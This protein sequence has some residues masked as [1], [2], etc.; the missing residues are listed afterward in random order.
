MTFQPRERQNIPESPQP[1]EGDERKKWYSGVR[2]FFRPPLS[3]KHF[4][5]GGI[6]LF[7]IV[8]GAIALVYLYAQSSFDRTWVA[9]NISGP[10]GVTSGEEVIYRVDCKNST[11]VN[12]NDAQLVFNWPAD[13]IP[14]SGQLIEQISI[15]TL[16]AGQE[17]VIEFKG[18]IIGLKNSQKQLSAK[19]SY[20]P[21]KTNARFEN[22]ST[23]A[24]RIISI[25]LVLTFDM[26]QRVANGQQITVSLKYLNDSESSFDNL[27]VKIEYPDG[28][29]VS[30]SYPQ[31]QENVW[32]IGKLDSKQ[33]GKILITGTIEGERGDAKLF[34]GYLGVMNNG[35]TAYA[36][37][38]KS[39]Q[40]SLPVLSL[41]QTVNGASEYIA[42]PG[43]ELKYSIKYQNNSAISIPS[44]KIVLKFNTQALDFT[45][46]QLNDKGSFESVGNSITWDQTNA[47][48]LAVVGA[49]YQGEFKFSVKVKDAMPIKAYSDKN[50]VIY[51]VVNSSST[52]IPLAL[53]D[54]QFQ[55]T[56]ELSIKVNSKLGLDARGYYQDTFLPN[57]G[58]IPPKVGEVTTYTIYWYV[59]NSSNDVE[60]ARV[61][62]ILPSYVE[63]LNKFKPAS[64]NFQYDNLNRRVSWDIGTLP[65]GT[66]VLSPAKYVAFQVGLTPSAPQIN[67]VV[68][69]I[70]QSL[71]T[72]KDSFTGADLKTSDAQIGSDVPD[73]PTIT[74]DKG[75]VTQ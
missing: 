40:I 65:A 48:E 38:V 58:P 67:Q 71:V 37:A 8:A 51:D 11:K 12:L 68:T 75:R 9:L 23:F 16:T 2:D 73:D 35:F 13:S 19:L 41:A 69:L 17:K 5:I 56:A 45:T 7:L 4:W 74:W 72:G 57:N 28:F 29:K 44:V 60:D 32:N 61:E 10:D 70:N 1:P 31:P 55:D 21:A 18:K 62:A 15:G 26:P 36:D 59:T 3:A 66:G 43:E 50:F 49:G 54:Q 22:V 33:E 24:S 6:V 27:F 63:W 53:I 52:N 46:L 39:A 34:H 47:P 30:S 20:Q 25:P 64:I 42:N 14:D